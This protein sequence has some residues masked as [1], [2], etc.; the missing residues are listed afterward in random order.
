MRLRTVL[1]ATIFSLLITASASAQVGRIEGD[2]KGR[3]AD[4]TLVPIEGA[5]VDIV[6]VDIKG[7]YT[8]KTDKKGH[9]IH[10]GVPY[11]GTYTVMV[12]APGWAPTFATGVRPDREPVN[13]E[14]APGDGSKL[15]IEKIQ[16]I[17]KQQ[18]PAAGGQQ[19]KMSEEERQRILKE[20]QRQREE[21]EKAQKSFD[22][23]KK[24]FDEGNR[25]LSANDYEGA[26]KEFQQAAELDP[27]Q[28]VI[29]AQLAQSLF[30]AGVV[31][32]NKQQRDEAKEFFTKSI[33][34]GKKA[35][36]VLSGTQNAT[37]NP[38]YHKILSDPLRILAL[39]YGSQDS[40]K[41]A[42]AQYEIMAGLATTP[43]DKAR[44]LVSIGDMYFEGGKI[45]EAIAA[46]EKVLETDPNNYAALHGKAKSL[47]STG[48]EAK[49]QEGVNLMAK[50]VELAPKE[51]REA[52]EA[53]E[54]IAMI[55]EA[56]SLQ[57]QKDKDKDKDKDK[58]PAPRRKP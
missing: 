24:H 13:F 50:V 55:K 45:E 42:I 20:Q 10:A 25:L 6:R 36:E 49:V 58:K 52:K 5:I 57:P 46:Y 34:A 23:M 44:S 39:R 7:N 15:T 9:Y 43:A 1:F 48:E 8:V 14:L 2:V 33:E 29:F 51:S 35:I 16:Q 19:P 40:L 26:A 53:T 11:V 12:S 38:T 54:M 28:H 17:T 56:Y 27:S 21:A 32:F 18:P 4:G 41:E 30:N 3:K 31:R 37:P 22:E 47:V